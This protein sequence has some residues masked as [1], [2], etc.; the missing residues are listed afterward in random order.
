MGFSSSLKV[1]Y[2]VTESLVFA[3]GGRSS[4]GTRA[5]CYRGTEIDQREYTCCIYS[6]WWL[7]RT[8]VGY[9]DHKE[10]QGW[11]EDSELAN[12]NK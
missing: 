3:V 8:L 4:F 9:L 7:A 6:I 2:T 5:D 11:S 1:D 10:V 12:V